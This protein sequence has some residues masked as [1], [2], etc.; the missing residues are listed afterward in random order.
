MPIKEEVEY[1]G[2]VPTEDLKRKRLITRLNPNLK[3]ENF[4]I[5]DKVP[6]QTLKEK[7]DNII[8]FCPPVK[9]HSSFKKES[10]SIS[11][12][13]DKFF[14]LNKLYD[15]VYLNGR[16]QTTKG[17]YRSMIDIFLITRHYFPRIALATVI[18]NVIKDREGNPRLNSQLCNQIKRRVY[19]IRTDGQHRGPVSKDELD[20]TVE[21]LKGIK[22]E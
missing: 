8:A 10:N 20:F 16:T 2:A 17:K 15:T 19:D 6:G 1:C 11:E 14:E 22:K 13:L 5:F 21:E 9:F 4:T 3:Y 12:F 7:A 18:I